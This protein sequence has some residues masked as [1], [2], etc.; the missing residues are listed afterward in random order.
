MFQDLR[1]YD[2][3]LREHKNKSWCIILLPGSE[4]SGYALGVQI[5]VVL[6]HITDDLIAPL[7]QLLALFNGNQRFA[8]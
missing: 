5:S 7:W 6:L 2:L 1:Y 8:A 4:V 3:Q